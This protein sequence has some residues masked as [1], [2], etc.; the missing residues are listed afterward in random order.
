MEVPALR[1]AG[2]DGDALS[3]VGHEGFCLQL[4][5]RGER[6]RAVYRLDDVVGSL[7]SVIIRIVQDSSSAY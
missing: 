6:E 2:G 7:P 3:G 5:G 4:H 1:E